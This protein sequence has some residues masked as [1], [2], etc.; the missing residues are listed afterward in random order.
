MRVTRENPIFIGSKEASY[1]TKEIKGKSV[2]ID[3]ETYF[4]IS[5]SDEMRPFFMSIVSVSKQ[6]MFIES[7][8]GMT[9]GRK[10]NGP[11]LFPSETEDKNT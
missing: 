3:N 11:A 4:K 5:N 2:V 6:L 9:A 10:D 8:G 7:N 1:T